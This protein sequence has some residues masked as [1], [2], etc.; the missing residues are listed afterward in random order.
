MGYFGGVDNIV[1]LFIP[2]IF[3]CSGGLFISR[4][5]GFSKDGGGSWVGVF[6]FDRA[7]GFEIIGCGFNFN[8]A[9]ACNS[10]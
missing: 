5:Y 2:Y 8:Y 9:W 4:L 3:G 6:C 1:T 7:I 10:G